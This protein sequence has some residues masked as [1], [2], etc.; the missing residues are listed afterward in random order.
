[1]L[2]DCHDGVSK[3]PS[4]DPWLTY[5]GESPFFMQYMRTLR[6]KMFLLLDRD[7]ARLAKALKGAAALKE[8]EIITPQSRE[9]N[10]MA[11]RKTFRSCRL[12]TLR[13]LVV[14]AGLE[15]FVGFLDVSDSLE[16]WNEAGY[17]CLS[18]DMLQTF[19]IEGHLRTITQLWLGETTPWSPLLLQ[20]LSKHLPHL[21]VLGVVCGGP[22]GYSY[23]ALFQQS[24]LF[25]LLE[26]L[27][28]SPVNEIGLRR[29]PQSCSNGCNKPDERLRKKKF[30]YDCLP[31][32][33]DYAGQ[34]A[35]YA[36]PRL[37]TVE[38]QKQGRLTQVHH[39][40]GDLRRVDIDVRYQEKATLAR[41]H[42]SRD[43]NG[44]VSATSAEPADRPVVQGQRVYN[45]FQIERARSRD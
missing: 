43:H 29:Y 3:L 19:V 9:N 31:G 33:V 20:T 15:D 8:L 2:T 42:C 17:S 32:A 16:I 1:M 21:K 26:R 11:L 44:S 24:D 36:L 22:P 35:F 6:I 28:L 12:P 25:P 39:D 10:Q 27:I 40:T 45:L 4:I 38:F 13:S 41:L 37:R 34:V 18:T 23:E 14:S 5:V 30:C 7:A